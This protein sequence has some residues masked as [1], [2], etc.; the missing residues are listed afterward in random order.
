MILG[1]DHIALSGL[2]LDADGSVLTSLGGTREW[3]QPGTPNMPQKQA[4]LSRWHPLHDLAVHAFPMGPRIEITCHG[5][6]VPGVHQGFVPVFSGPQTFENTASDD[7]LAA[8]LTHALGLETDPALCTLPNG[9]QCWVTNGD[10]GLVGAMHVVPD[11]AASVDWMTGVLGA[12]S[13]G[14]GHSNGTDWQAVGWVS[15]IKAWSMKLVLVQDGGSER[16]TPSLLEGGGIPLDAAGWPCLAL[17]TSDLAGDH[18][19]ALAPLAA[20]ETSFRESLTINGRTVAF[21]L[22][23]GPGGELIELLQLSR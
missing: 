11:L 9:A 7:T 10:P 2:D 8:L 6:A 13:I 4:F 20:T 21:A 17:L 19:K 15:P 23:R 3:A 16:P 1:V 14:Q 22:M 5:Q 12:R 18:G